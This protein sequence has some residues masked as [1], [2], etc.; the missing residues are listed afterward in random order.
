MSQQLGIKE[1]LNLEIT[2]YSDGSPIF[3]A[4]YASN[5]TIETNADRLFLEGGQ[6]AYRLLAFDYRK[7]MT[8]KITL[9]LVDLSFLSN[10][11]GQNLY[12]G[13]VNVPNHEILIANAS[14]QIT[15]ASTPVSGTLK[16]WLL[17]G[18]RDYGTE[19]VAGTPASNQNQYSITGR[20]VTLNATTAPTG[21]KFVVQYDYA[22]A[23]TTRTITFSAD[24]FADYVNINGYGLVTDQVTGAT[25]PTVFDIKKAKP[26]N[27][28]TLTMSSTEATTLEMTFDLFFVQA[29]AADGTTQKIYVTMHELA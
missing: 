9:P 21:T 28:F 11:T 12:T 25:V 6:G 19:Q 27:V 1:V 24:K 29:T 2:K 23:A 3:F 10:I 15:V 4:D 18:D 14:N 8:A 5:T 20:V 7:T 17:S 16:I 22:S 26:Q 13:A